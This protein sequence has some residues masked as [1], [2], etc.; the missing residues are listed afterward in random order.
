MKKQAMPILVLITAVFAA[1]TMGFFIGRNQQGSPVLVT[2]L[3]TDSQHATQAAETTETRTESKTEAP[4][5]EEISATQAITYPININTADA[6]TLIELPGIGQVLAD[7][8]I[9][10]RQEHGAFTAVEELMNVEG[11]GAGKL[12]DILNLVTTG[13]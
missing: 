1:F 13:G 6:Y 11:I 5:Q 12:E 2:S 9:A 3:H 10:Y 8:I 7:R 4:T